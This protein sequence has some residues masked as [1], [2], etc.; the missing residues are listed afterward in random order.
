MRTAFMRAL[1]E[2][3]AH[4][5]RITL[6][7]GDL[8][9]SVVEEFASKYPKQYLN[10]GVAEQNMTGVAAGMA[11]AGRTVFTYSIA[12][13]PTLRCLEQ[14]RNDVCY[15]NAN[16]K[17][18]AVGGGFAYGSLG[19]SHHAT[20]DLAILRTLPNMTV[21]APGDPVE[22]GHAAR[23][24]ARQ[25]GPAYIRLGKAGEPRVHQDDVAFTIG[26]AIVVREGADIALLSTGGMLPDVVKAAEILARDHAVVARVLS[27][28]TIKP[29][30]IDA[31]TRAA[32]ETELVVTVEEHS[33]IGGLGG[34]VAEVLA[35]LETP[36]RLKRI[37]LPSAFSRPVGT[38]DYMRAAHGLT[39]DGIVSSVV[40]ALRAKTVRAR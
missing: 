25:P 27:V 4:D 34:A 33:E 7:V 21:I 24:V 20:E 10:A 1:F 26:R 16:V 40:S 14:I 35:E 11:L 32:H 36:A 8:G 6:V 19:A 30:D 9:Y 2:E 13:F 23:A 22:A 38:R 5:P 28:H 17:V 3:A 12:N 39:T 37:A 15:H 29:L 31:V 18:V